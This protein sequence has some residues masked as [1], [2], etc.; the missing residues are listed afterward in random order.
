MGIGHWALGIGK[1]TTTNYQPQRGSPVAC[2]R[3]TLPQRPFT[4]NPTGEPVTCARVTLPQYWFTTN[5]QPPTPSGFTIAGTRETLPLSAPSPPT[6][7]E[8]QLPALVLPSRSTGS[9]PTTNHQPP[10]KS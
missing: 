1:K 8:N 9:P 2:A 7:R 4:T 6:Q 3:V 10:T 5:H